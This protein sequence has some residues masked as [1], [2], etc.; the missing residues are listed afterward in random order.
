MG[1]D[2][3]LLAFR[4]GAIWVAKLAGCYACR[5]VLLSRGDRHVGRVIPDGQVRT[6]DVP[7]KLN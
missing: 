1:K 2:T 5:K 3:V 6:P 7:K 4:V